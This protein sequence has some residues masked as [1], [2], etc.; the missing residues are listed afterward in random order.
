MCQALIH[1]SGMSAV[2]QLMRALSLVLIRQA[3]A[4]TSALFAE[5]ASP[6]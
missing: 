6:F 3:G 2:F 1:I 5:G 4:A